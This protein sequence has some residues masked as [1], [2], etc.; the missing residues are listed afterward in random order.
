MKQTLKTSIAL[1]IVLI[2]GYN[3]YTSQQDVKMFSLTLAN[4]EALAMDETSQMW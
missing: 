4:I 2:A 1:V 3:V